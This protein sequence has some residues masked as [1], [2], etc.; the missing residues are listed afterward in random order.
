MK[1]RM[2]I[3]VSSIVVFVGVIGF[4]KF[5]QI[6]AAIAQGAAFQMPPEA[7]TTILAASDEWEASLGAI[8][9]VSAVR[10]VVV[11]ADLPGVVAALTFDSGQRV[12][13]GE[14]L[15]TLDTRQEQAQLAAAE[16]QCDLT[17]ANLE[18]VRELRAKGVT[19]QAEFDR[20][21]AEA[22]AAQARA[23]EIRAVIERKTIRAPFA[24]SLG[25]RQVNLGQYLE[26]GAPVVPLQALDPVYV[27][28]SVPQQT[29][30]Q[31]RV[32]A[33]VHV[34]VE[35]TSEVAA[36]GRVT[37]INSVIDEATRNVEAQATLKNRDGALLPG[38]FVTVRVMMGQS[39]PVVALPASA[40]S[41]APYGNSVFIVE[42]VA[43]PDGGTYR[44]VRQQ[45]VKLGAAR[46]D[47]VAVLDGVQ[48]GEEVVTSG[49]FKLRAGAAVEVHNDVVPSNDPAPKP[50]DS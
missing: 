30:H 7:V 39:D 49:V 45:F 35:G 9:T 13:A 29:M 33:E 47:Q 18:R 25:I 17:R 8:G 15:V 14:V 50:E 11:S 6:R 5:M 10:G 44:G 28:F 38:M 24:G 26:G 48:A 31:L 1:K 12:Q 43:G 22:K 2:I 23:D 20:V 36:R 3:M 34:E 37:A 4:I 27:N 19:S 42:D 16:A 40:I 41:Y 21:D 32:G 46:G